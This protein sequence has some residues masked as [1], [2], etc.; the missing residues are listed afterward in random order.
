[1]EI[2]DAMKDTKYRRTLEDLRK[3]IHNAHGN[4]NE[5]ISAVL[6]MTCTAVHAEAGTFWFYSRFGDGLIHPRAWY[7]GSNISQHYLTPGEGVAGTVIETGVPSMIADCQ[8][9]PR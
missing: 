9:D 3:V 6:N 8:K 7:G 5:A 1:M 4:L 2:W